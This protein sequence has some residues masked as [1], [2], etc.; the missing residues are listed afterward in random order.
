MDQKLELAKQL[1]ATHV[2]NSSNNE[3]PSGEI[4]QIVDGGVDYSL[5]CVGSSDLVAQSVYS[6]VRGGKIISVGAIPFGQKIQFDVMALFMKTLMGS[7]GGGSRPEIDIPLYEQMFVGNK[8]PLDK[9]VT[10]KFPFEKI[11]A[12]FQALKGGD[13]I[14]CVL[15]F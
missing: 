12:A 7:V 2:I 11:N 5:E 10:H 1:G 4:I 13:V 9:L 8:I 6:T 14:K 3:Q 15:M